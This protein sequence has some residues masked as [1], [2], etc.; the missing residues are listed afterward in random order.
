MAV[1]SEQLKAILEK[2]YASQ[3]DFNGDPATDMLNPAAH[4]LLLPYAS[5]SLFTTGDL[6]LFR[7]YFNYDGEQR[8]ATLLGP[9]GPIRTWPI[10]PDCP[11]VDGVR[12]TYGIRF[13]Q[14][15]AGDLIW[16]FF[17]ERMGI[18]RMVGALLDD[19]VSKG[20]FP[21]R[22][23][24]ISGL[25]MEAMVREL[26]CGLSSTV[27]ERDTSLRLCLGWTTEAGS[28][29]GNDATIN[30][31]FSEQF[32]RLISLSLAYY[33]EKR[34]A[35]AIQ[36][37]ANAG[38]PSVA[39]LTSIRDTIVLLRKACDPFKYGRN[40]TH[41][42]SGIVW[43]LSGLDILSRLRA[44]LGIPEPYDRFDELI[45][46][47]HDLLLG[48]TSDRNRYT[49]HRD[50]AVHGRDIMLDV[51]GMDFEAIGSPSSEGIV[52]SWLNDVNV[53]VEAKFET[54]RT[55]YRALTGADLGQAGAAIE[56][57]A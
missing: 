54:Y 24:G 15:F 28:R 2:Q 19:F 44:Q 7:Q 25:V 50:C 29:L 1:T 57:R 36:A 18:H 11:R 26:K 13:Q 21:L 52:E 46:A 56:Q 49:M 41:T 30:R 40:H 34:L 48:G 31:T 17:H 5:S 47:A 39:T 10:P 33:Q 14:L 53:N 12:G 16:L 45:P 9:C 32:H 8:A 37:S 22:P 6:R 51:Q 35:V 38:K 3:V 4:N 55:A 27:R 43:T 23:S 20:R 42:L